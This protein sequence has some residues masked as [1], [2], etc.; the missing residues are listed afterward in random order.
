M[1]DFREDLLLELRGVETEAAE[2]LEYWRKPQIPIPDIE[3]GNRLRGIARQ[4]RNVSN[5]TLEDSVE[6]LVYARAR[7]PADL[8]SLITASQKEHESALLAIVEAGGERADVVPPLDRQDMFARRANAL[9]GAV[10]LALTAW[11][12]LTGQSPE[13]LVDRE[14]TRTLAESAD[15]KA[16]LGKT[17]QAEEDLALARN[18]VQAQATQDTE[19]AAQDATAQINHLQ[20]LIGL[21]RGEVGGKK[22]RPS[23]MIYLGKA[24]KPKPQKLSLTLAEAKFVL[25]MVRATSTAVESVSTNLIVYLEEVADA[26]EDVNTAYDKTSAPP[27]PPFEIDEI[28]ENL[29]KGN[30]PHPAHIPRIEMLNFMDEKRLVDLSALSGLTGLQTLYLDGTGVSDVSA[31]SGLTGLQTLY[32]NGTGVTDEDLVVLQPLIDAGLSVLR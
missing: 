25:K 23:L 29:I 27:P 14:A 13:D 12:E 17:K 15:V 16:V 11:T 32:L 3:E 8:R 21:W 4:L 30:P 28:M 18:E 6:V 7:I 19:L 10:G 22:V 2:L 31:L 1:E 5:G 9:F 20:R 24:I 26:I